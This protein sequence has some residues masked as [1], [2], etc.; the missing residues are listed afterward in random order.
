MQPQPYVRLYDLTTY[1]QNNS[2]APYNASQHDAEFDAIKE[3]LDETLANLTLIQRDDGNLRMAIVTPDA[4]S[5]ATLNLMGDWNPRGPWLPAQSYAVRDMV[6]ISFTT[7]YVCATAHTS[8]AF[9]TDLALGYWQRV[10]GSASDATTVTFSTN[11]VILGRVSAGSGD[12]EEIACTAFARTLL[13]DADAAT[14]RTT[15]GLGSGSDPTFSDV[16]AATLTLS[17]LTANAFL[18]SGTAGLLTTTAAPT[19]GQL[20]IGDTGGAPVAAT[21][22]GTANQVS[23]TNAAGSITLALL[24]CA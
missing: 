2:A 12:G 7:S 24:F 3:T 18:Y 22:T 6:T 16:I 14:A 4:L 17:G 21:L 8:S 5:E 11:D 13:D 23:V 1:A 20:L 10:N 19:D 15:L 9:A